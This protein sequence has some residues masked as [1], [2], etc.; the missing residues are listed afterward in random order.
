MFS[1]IKIFSYADKCM[2]AKQKKTLYVT[3]MSDRVE[4]KNSSSRKLPLTG[5]T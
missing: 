3:V 1:V 5:K 4:E 2:E